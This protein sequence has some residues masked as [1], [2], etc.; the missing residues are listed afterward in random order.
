MTW[1]SVECY[2][3][4]ATV[5]FVLYLCVCV[6]GFKKFSRARARAHRT[7]STQ[8]LVKKRLFPCCNYIAV[9]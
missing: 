6:C 1:T 7:W 2:L 3:V 4:F 8:N 9:V 5:V